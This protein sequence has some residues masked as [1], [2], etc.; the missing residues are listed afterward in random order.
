I[1]DGP[2]DIPKTIQTRPTSRFLT[3]PATNE[4]SRRS[5]QRL[6]VRRLRVH[7]RRSKSRQLSTRRQPSRQLLRSGRKAGPLATC[8]P[9]APGPLFAKRPGLVAIAKRLSC[10]AAS[11]LFWRLRSM[12][13]QQRRSV[14]VSKSFRRHR[15]TADRQRRGAY[16]WSTAADREPLFQPGPHYAHASKFHNQSPLERTRERS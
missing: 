4:L 16:Q 14:Q 2:T 10:E 9:K 13:Q 1:A 8:A 5:R 6:P 11:L 12:L 3:R 15:Q 7:S